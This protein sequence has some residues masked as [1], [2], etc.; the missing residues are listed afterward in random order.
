MHVHAVSTLQVPQWT[1]SLT[2]GL[3]DASLSFSSSDWLTTFSLLFSGLRP[4]DGAER[5]HSN[6]PRGVH[7]R[8][9][10]CRLHTA[11]RSY[12]AISRRI[13]TAEWPRPGIMSLASVQL[14]GRSQSRRRHSSP[15]TWA[16]PDRRMP[17]SSG[18]MVVVRIHYSDI[19]SNE[20]IRKHH[21]I[22]YGS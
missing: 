7:S 19:S 6:S 14:D 20:V 13:S 9:P 21:R 8:L 17:L 16:G 1:T 3:P 22:V 18:P 11:R 4:R 10:L 15:L 2:N 12:R 5:W